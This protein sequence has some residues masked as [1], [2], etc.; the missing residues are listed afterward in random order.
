MEG[1][2]EMKM[3]LWIALAAA[4]MLTACADT[5]VAIPVTQ[6]VVVQPDDATYNT[7]AQTVDVPVVT[8]TN[9][10]AAAV[11]VLYGAYSSCRQTVLD[12]KSEIAR[13]K[14][15]AERDNKKTN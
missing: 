5:E 13:L 7:C 15:I 2:A 3:N 4:L 10:G 8:D 1:E 12:I 11:R 14:A 9:S 6:T